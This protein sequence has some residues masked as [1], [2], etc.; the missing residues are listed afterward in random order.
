MAKIRRSFYLIFYW[1]GD[2]TQ[3]F[4]TLVR[5]TDD[6][7]L[8]KHVRKYRNEFRTTVKSTTNYGPITFVQKEF[9]TASSYVEVSR[10]IHERIILFGDKFLY[11]DALFTFPKSILARHF[12]TQFGHRCS[13]FH[14]RPTY[15][16]S[17]SKQT[18]IR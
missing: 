3:K 10:Y 12:V 15:Y 2:V 5:N 6:L 18:I 14:K 4:L 11:L 9:S 16:S 1:Y 17:D 7:I 8:K 13:E